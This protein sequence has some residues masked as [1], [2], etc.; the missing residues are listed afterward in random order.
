M[1]P[2]GDVSVMPQAWQRRT[3]SLSYASIRDGGQ[4]APPM[5]TLAMEERSRGF[6]VTSAS[7]PCQM[8][9]TAAAWVGRSRSIIS[10]SG[11]GWRKRS[12]ISM[13]TPVMNVACG[14]PHA[15]TWNWGTTTSV[16]SLSVSPIDSA[17]LTCMECR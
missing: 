8:V 17:M 11:A 1:V 6:A 4:A 12:G 9:G 16:V 15:F 3:P 2:S 5:V 13:L 10:A 14:S 7:S